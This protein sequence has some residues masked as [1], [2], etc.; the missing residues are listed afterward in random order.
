MS[1]DHL[2]DHGECL[3]GSEPICRSELADYMRDLAERKP[4]SRGT[5]TV[6]L[7]HLGEWRGF[8]R[9]AI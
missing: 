1:D 5:V 8:E 9:E 4:L 7:K 6:L 2:I 3:C